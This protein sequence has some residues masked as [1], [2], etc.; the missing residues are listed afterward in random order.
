MNKPMG[1]VQNPKL[2]FFAGGGVTSTAADY[3]QRATEAIQ[4]NQQRKVFEGLMKSQIQGANAAYEDAVKAFPVGENGED[5]KNWIPRP[6]MFVDE[7]TGAFMPYKYY[8]SFATGVK[9][10]KKQQL[11]VTKANNDA[12]REDRMATHQQTMETQGATRIEQGERRADIAEAN[13]AI[14]A[15]RAA[16][17]ERKNQAKEDFDTEKMLQ[18]EAKTY[19]S[20]VQ[21][22][23]KIY[24]T[25]FDE[26]V[27]KEQ[28]NIY[29]NNIRSLRN[30][31]ENIMQAKAIR[32]GI[33]ISDEAIK[34]AL[35][36]QD[37]TDLQDQYESAY[38]RF[39]EPE[40]D[41]RGVAEVPEKY[42]DFMTSFGNNFDFKYGHQAVMLRKKGIS[43]EASRI[44]QYAKKIGAS[45]P[46]NPIDIPMVE[47]WL[48]KTSIENVIQGIL[49]TRDQLKNKS[50]SNSIGR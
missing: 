8:Q 23:I 46:E 7:K 31:N 20:A 45:N 40:R 37:A 6:E 48:N 9:E 30:A 17:S 2:N 15:Q 33:E 13:T 36:I 38:G 44:V 21:N 49:I 16:E 22:A 27:R 25:S 12:A 14:G 1:A 5:I 10:F 34:V 28:L 42:T 39:L 11:D 47:E 41:D 50:K 26:K 29:K 24:G 19:R 3:T 18:N 43:P 32:S 35:D 4:K